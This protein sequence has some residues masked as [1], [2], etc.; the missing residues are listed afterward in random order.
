MQ[1]HIVRDISASELANALELD[2]YGDS[3]QLIRTVGSLENIESNVLK[4]CQ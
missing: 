1:Y 2:F 4:F 3:E